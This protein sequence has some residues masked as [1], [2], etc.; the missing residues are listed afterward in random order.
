MALV[1]L[2]TVYKLS[3]VHIT[4]STCIYIYIFFRL[5][6]MSDTKVIIRAI[7]FD[8]DGVLMIPWTYPEECFPQIRCILK[9][10]VNNQISLAATSFNPHAWKALSNNDLLCHFQAVRAGCNVSWDY[11]NPAVYVNKTHRQHLCKSKQIMDIL[12]NE[13]SK[14]GLSKKEILLID[15][16]A[17]NIRSAKKCGFQTLFVNDSYLGLDWSQLQILMPYLTSPSMTDA[18]LLGMPIDNVMIALTKVSI[19]TKFLSLLKTNEN[20]AEINAVLNFLGQVTKKAKRQ[21][22][23]KCA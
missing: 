2:T 11:M 18:L 19:A 7:A 22:E 9:H 1:S 12:A 21:E 17:N 16:D 23:L 4:D 14:L 13:W 10:L 8:F 20:P 6:P 15:D 5:I 3:F